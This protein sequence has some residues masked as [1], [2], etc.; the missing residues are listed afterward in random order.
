MLFV[1][2]LSPA[3][4]KQIAD[5]ME[6]GR[7]ASVDDMASEAFNILLKAPSVSLDSPASTR[8]EFVADDPGSADRLSWQVP[9]SAGAVGVATVEGSSPPMWMWG[10]VNRVF[11]MKI[12]ARVCASLCARGPVSLHVVQ[13]RSADV[14]SRIGQV[15]ALQ[16]RVKNRRRNEARAVA[17]PGGD[18]VQKSKIR[19]AFQFVGRRSEER[20][21]V[22]GVFDAGLLGRVGDDFLIAPTSV[23]WDFA[24]LPN[25]VL[26]GRAID[27]KG[28]NLSREECDYYMT[29]VVRSVPAERDAFKT[30]LTSLSHGPLTPEGLARAVAPHVGAHVSTA[31]A[32]TARSG[33][34]GRLADVRGIV[35]VTKGRSALFSI[36]DLGRETLSQLTRGT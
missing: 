3:L 17:L 20:P 6:T 27:D 5:I 29:E 26:D 34:L 4:A 11:P 8:R 14:A 21:F 36:T 9:E 23:G 35:R 7:Y 24:R 10:M 31:V 12:V 18:D 28:W 25:P 33:A 22:G 32:D 16:D 15:L 13:R 19:F 2:N 30:I 1:F